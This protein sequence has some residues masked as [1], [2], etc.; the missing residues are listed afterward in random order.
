M[1]GRRSARGNGVGFLPL[2]LFLLA[3]PFSFEF[4][5]FYPRLYNERHMDS[6]IVAP[7][8]SLSPFLN[9][10]HYTKLV[11]EK[12]KSSFHISFKVKLKIPIENP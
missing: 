3:A 4:S 10:E 5:F 2:S 6:P 12:T 11:E 1:S 9:V 7:R 8:G